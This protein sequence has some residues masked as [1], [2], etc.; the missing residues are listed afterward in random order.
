M[1]LLHRDGYSQCKLCRKPEIPQRSSW[2]VAAPV[3]VND[4]CHGWSRQCRMLWRF[5]S[6]SSWTW[7]SCPLCTDRVLVQTVCKLFGGATR[8]S[9][10]H[11]SLLR[12]SHLSRGLQA[13]AHFLGALDD[14]EFLVVEGS[15]GDGDAR[16]QT[17]RWPATN[18]SQWL[19]CTDSQAW[20]YTLL[21][22]CPE[23]T[24]TTKTTTTT[25]RYGSQALP[26]R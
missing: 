26:F 12:F 14:E 16:R 17:P 13:G 20:T 15:G 21:M 25:R 3:I 6:C 8:K 7:S 9:D 10:A 22:P 23:T 18:W 2:M 5:R 4:R 1:Q 24:T 19:R 11:A